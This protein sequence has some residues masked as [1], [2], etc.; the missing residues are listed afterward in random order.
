MEKCQRIILLLRKFRNP[1]S[2]VA[3]AVESVGGRCCGPNE[4][5]SIIRSQN[6][7]LGNDR[8]MLKCYRGLVRT[9]LSTRVAY[10]IRKGARRRATDL[11]GVEAVVPGRNDHHAVAVNVHPIRRRTAPRQVRC[12]FPTY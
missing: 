1:F 10:S 6:A 2:G 8:R 9:G 3:A 11:I 4:H 5:S 12:P 7:S